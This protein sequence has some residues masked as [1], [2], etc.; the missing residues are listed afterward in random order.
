MMSE[1]TFFKNNIVLIGFMGTGKSCVAHHLHNLYHMDVAE[2]DEM[3]VKQEGMSIPDIFSSKGDTYF[4][5][6]E[7]N[8]LYDLQ[9]EN[10]LVISCGGGAALRK[11]NVE[12]MKQNGYVFL[13]TASPETIYQRVGHDLNRPVLNGRR[14]PEGIRA[15]MESRRKKYEATADCI[16]STEQLTSKEV[17]QKI[18]K[19]FEQLNQR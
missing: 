15:L 4:R 18:M 10:H 16:I 5:N 1:R 17:A 9:K 13:L 8:L 3:I 11:E 2:M 14:S 7:T 6:L 12:A 19:L